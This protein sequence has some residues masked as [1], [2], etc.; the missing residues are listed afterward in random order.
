MRR[1]DLSQL[2]AAADVIDE[3]AGALG[4]VDVLVNNAGTVRP[5]AFLDMTWEDWRDVL[6]V[7]LDGGFTLVNPQFRSTNLD[8]AD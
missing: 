3:L 2:P 6:S 5:S 1:L 7:N 8:A 4:R